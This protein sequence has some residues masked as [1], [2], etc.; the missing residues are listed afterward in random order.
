MEWRQTEDG[1]PT[2]YHPFYREAYHPR[3]GAVRQAKLLYL[4]GTWT[5]L[6]P[7]PQVLEVG[8]GLGVNFRVTLENVLLRGVRLVY[9]AVEKE[10]LPIEALAFPLGLAS[11]EAF[12][13]LLK[14][15]PGPVEAPWGQFFLL[16]GDI[17]EVDLPEAFAT[18][19]Y[20]DPFSP[21]VNPGAWGL[22]VMQKLRRA[23][24]PGARLA[25]YSAAGWVRRNLKAA[26]FRVERI[27]S[28]WKREWTVGTALETPPG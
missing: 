11:D 25:T 2:L 26:G 28:P 16:I 12:L 10:P 17:R 22:E 14:R 23:A 20:L 27:P 15:L 19:I 21:R 5:H 3:E 24:L 1:S 18:A 13:E 6:H 9:V 8:F 4:E 7:F